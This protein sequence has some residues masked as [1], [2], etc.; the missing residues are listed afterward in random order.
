MHN[1]LAINQSITNEK[2]IARAHKGGKQGHVWTVNN[3][4]QMLR[5]LALGADA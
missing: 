1:S 3:P 2:F 5:M 4:R